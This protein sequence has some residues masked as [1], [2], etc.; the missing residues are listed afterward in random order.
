LVKLEVDDVEKILKGANDLK[1]QKDTEVRREDADVVRIPLSQ[2]E[3]NR[4]LAERGGFG[5]SNVT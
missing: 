2:V 3:A 1:L 4:C 5:N